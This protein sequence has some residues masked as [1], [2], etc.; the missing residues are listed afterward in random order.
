MLKL[1][2]RPA[3]PDDRDFKLARYFDHKGLHGF[4]LATLKADLEAL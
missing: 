3:T 4:D 1:G 2:K